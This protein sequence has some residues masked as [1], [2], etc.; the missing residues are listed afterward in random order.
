MIYVLIFQTIVL[1]WLATKLYEGIQTIKMASARFTMLMNTIVM[2][3][4]MKKPDKTYYTAKAL[5]DLGEAKRK[6]V[7]DA[8]DEDERKMAIDDLE[9]LGL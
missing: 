2:M 1:L 6:L 4:S 5:S 9:K 7:L 8:M 3:D